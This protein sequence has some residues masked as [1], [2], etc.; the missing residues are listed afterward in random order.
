MVPSAPMTTAAVLLAAGAGSRF[1]GP[2]HKLLAPWG[3]GTVAGSAIE[4]VVAAG[5]DEVIVVT[6]AV[7]LGALV[8]GLTVLP[9]PHW[10]RGQATSLRLAVEHAE[11]AGHDAVV[12]GLADQPGVP[13]SA[14]RAVAASDAPIAAARFAEGRRPPVRL[15]REVWSMLPDSGDEG[16][17]ALLAE[18][19]ELVTEIDV[20]G[21][22][23]DIDTADDLFTDADRAYVRECL[24]RAPR[25]NFSVAARDDRG[26]PTVI[27]NEPFLDD[28]TPMPT[29]F[30][31]IDPD[32]N[33]RI[34]TLEASGGVN[35]AEA[36]I[37]MQALADT[38]RRY[39]ALRDA[40]IPADR[41]GPRPSGGVGGTRLGVKCLHTHY[42]WFLAGGDD[43]VGRWVR[44]HLDQSVPRSVRPLATQSGPS[45]QSGHDATSHDIT[46]QGL[47][48]R[49][50]EQQ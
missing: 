33:R 47:G 21:D 6:G 19:P 17:R 38:H 23:R 12:V 4:S 2:T 27:D 20:A 11:A 30:W 32:L 3:A 35:R 43:A 29:M 13:E 10:A 41:S 22:P 7:D 28:G 31:L 42:A 26:R 25:C 14:W 1:V 5:F 34:G 24:G 9:N 49:D 8:D 15:G 48:A 36:E 37:G 16:A 40:R 18:H 39:A 50:R 44:A 46:K 45:R